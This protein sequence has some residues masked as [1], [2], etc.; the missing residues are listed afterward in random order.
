MKHDGA[1]IA[2]AYVGEVV[3]T[4]L[5]VATVLILDHNSVLPR[6]N[7]SKVMG[8][9]HKV[10]A[11]NLLAGV[12]GWAAIPGI[13]FFLLEFAGDA[14][15]RQI[16]EHEGLMPYV[17]AYGLTT[18][19]VA[20]TYYATPLLLLGG[21][22]SY[23]IVVFLWLYSGILLLTATRTTLAILVMVQQLYRLE[24][25]LREGKEGR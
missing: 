19:A 20:S 14:V 6:S 23:A 25:D 7:G 2:R 24:K 22:I 13:P 11:E 3:L 15:K 4:G 1:G 21:T 9:V 8:L 16:L 10:I 5:L 18:L 17:Y 12:I